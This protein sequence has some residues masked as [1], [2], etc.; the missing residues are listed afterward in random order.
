[1]SVLVAICFWVVVVV[2]VNRFLPRALFTGVHSGVGVCTV[3]PLWLMDF[4]EEG[5]DEA[6]CSVGLAA[7]QLR[8]GAS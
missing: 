5:V 6:E 7:L 1:M 2:A 8:R 4:Y 3:V